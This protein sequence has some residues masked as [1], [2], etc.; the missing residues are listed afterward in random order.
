MTRDQLLALP[1][2]VSRRMLEFIEAYRILSPG[3][4]F[5]SARAVYLELYPEEKE[6]KEEK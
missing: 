4:T 6:E 5:E 1:H 3:A 2:T